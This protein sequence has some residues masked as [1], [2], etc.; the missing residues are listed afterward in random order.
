M[1]G[2]GRLHCK[3]D[4]EAE[5]RRVGLDWPEET[6]AGRAAQHKGQVCIV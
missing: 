1:G 6:W 5:A 2:H 3:G 4:I